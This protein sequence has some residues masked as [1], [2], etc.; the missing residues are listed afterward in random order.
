[1]AEICS[2]PALEERDADSNASV[3]ERL[4]RGEVVYYPVCPFP[5]P[6][7]DDRTFLLEQQLGGR[8]HKNI[9]FD[10]R[11]GKAGGFLRHHQ[12]QAE[13]CPTCPSRR[14]ACYI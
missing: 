8:V 11:T 4:E 12:I 5:L 10:P 13:R 7:G 9:G 6:E 14:K 3:E 2:L 1:M